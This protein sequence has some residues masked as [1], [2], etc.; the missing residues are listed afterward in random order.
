MRLNS[1]E[2]HHLP[3]LSGSD[4]PAPALVHLGDILARLFMVGSGG[5]R[6]LPSPHATTIRNLGLSAQSL[7]EVITRFA[8]GLAR[9]TVF[10]GM[11]GEGSGPETINL[12][13]KSKHDKTLLIELANNMDRQFGGTEDPGIKALLE[14]SRSALTRMARS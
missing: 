2:S 4:D 9:S 6:R 13:L 3:E 8:K 5:G 7:D 11:L 12:L 14:A 1:I 10:F